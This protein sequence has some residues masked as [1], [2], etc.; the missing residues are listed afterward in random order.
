MRAILV[1]LRFFLRRAA[2]RLALGTLLLVATL[3]AG[4]GLF[5][6]SGWLIAGSALAGLGLIVFDTFRPS[7]GIRFF[8]V[9]RTVARY[10]E[11]LASHDATLRVLA[12]LRV[13]VFRG[14]AASP[15]P[16]QPGGRMLGRL[17]GDVDALDG[18]TIRLAAPAVATLVAGA[19][20]LVLLGAVSVPLALAVFVPALLGGLLVPVVL[21][22]R[23]T[24]DARRKLAALDA[25]RLRLA[26]LDRGRTDLA[27]AGRL[28]EKVAAVGDAATRAAV[29]ER[30]LA[31]REAVI[32]AA[33]LLGGQGAI[34]A[35][36]LV[37]AGLLAA[38]AISGP[39]FV[40][41]VIGAFAAIELVGPLRAGALDLG[42][43]AVAAR[44][45]APLVEVGERA[46]GTV[47]PAPAAGTAAA[48]LHFENVDFRWADD[49]PAILE[50][51]SGVVPAGRRIALVGPSG[52]GKSTLLALAAGLAR[53][54][55]GRVSLGGA[56]IAAPG[57]SESGAAIGLLTQST[58][59]FR[60]TIADNLRL[61]APEAADDDLLAACRTAGF[62]PVL[63]RLPAGLATGLGDGGSGLSG[64]ERRRLALARLILARP[65]LWLVDEPTEGL[66]AVAAAA[67]LAG[68]DAAI[69]SATALI[70]THR[71]EDAAIADE[72]WTLGTDG[73][74]AGVRP[75]GRELAGAGRR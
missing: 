21:G 52:V 1:I 67:V 64:G 30:R 56:G 23:A 16:A 59:L 36:A 22:L 65:A 75:G 57:R 47:T 24:R 42:R 15:G 11:R 74:V 63:E 32:R 54:D 17:S 8:A 49:R 33:G 14:L 69:G 50:N 20:G 73:R 68:L 31:R 27:L 58:R 12:A 9:G 3:A 29:A 71:P 48:S 37:G 13:A 18:L 26:D 41:V 38:G 34:A 62:A 72:I 4:A 35:A 7:A 55:A 39:L 28:G 6:V 45:L 46:A 70:V 2:G 61:A 40:A 25:V 60:G 10:A 43:T 51:F 66:D 19:A 5:A 44:R 53:P